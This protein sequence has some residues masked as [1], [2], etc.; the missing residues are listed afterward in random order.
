LALTLDWHPDGRVI[1]SGGRDK[2]IK[3]WDVKTQNRK[4]FHLIQTM[5][6]VAQVKW[7]PQYDTQIASCSLS[8]DYRILIYDLSRPWIPFASLDDHENVVSGIIWDSDDL[9]SCSK[10][11]MFIKSHVPS[12]SNRPIDSISDSCMAWTPQED[13]NIVF[14]DPQYRSG[15]YLPTKNTKMQNRWNDKVYI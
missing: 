3:F 14:S 13:F 5:A 15:F 11:S 12:S 6:P 7:R 2:I 10:D 4:P 9:Y 8:L 1:A